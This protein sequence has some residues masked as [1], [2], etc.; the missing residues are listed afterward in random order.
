MTKPEV[1][2]PEYGP[3]GPGHDP[4]KDPLKGLRGVMAGTL[5]MHAITVFL[6]L[7]VIINIDSGAHATPLAI[8]YVSGLAIAMT[9][10][11]FLQ[12]LRWALAVNLVLV[13]LGVLA[14]FFHWSLGFVGVFFALVWAYMLYLR[15]NL[16]ERMKCGLLTTQHD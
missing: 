13:A 8:G 10:M 1:H 14:V 9:V 11:A 6:G 4:V 7:L 5:V 15:S 3:L 2:D 12:R 16:I